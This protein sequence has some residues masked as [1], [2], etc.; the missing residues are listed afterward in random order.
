MSSQLSKRFHLSSKFCRKN[1]HRALVV[2]ITE[3]LR[4]Y[5]LSTEQETT[6]KSVTRVF[7][8]V[9]EFTCTPPTLVMILLTLSELGFYL[10][11]VLTT[12]RDIT[13]TGPVPYCSPL[14]YNPH[15]RQEAWRYVTYM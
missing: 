7:A 13:W 8:Y 6:L 1:K 10:H 14:I 15:R 12:D 9:E 2:L 11:T 3:V 4:D 5:R